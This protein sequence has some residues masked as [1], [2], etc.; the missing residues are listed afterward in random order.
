MVLVKLGVHTC[1]GSLR[2][3]FSSLHL[4]FSSF[5]KLPQVIR[6]LVF[7]VFF[8]VSKAKEPL[9]QTWA[10]VLSDTISE[11]SYLDKVLLSNQRKTYLK[12]RKD[13]FLV[14]CF[15]PITKHKAG[16]IA[17]TQSMSWIVLVE[18]LRSQRSTWR[19]GE[20]TR[21]WS[22]GRDSHLWREMA[23]SKEPP[24]FSFYSH[25]LPSGNSLFTFRK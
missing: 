9:S 17:S 24:Q 4:S 19:H 21:V 22:S 15:Y 25:I 7:S 1:L 23:H 13:I 5:Q 12:M 14:F 18:A 10:F 11:V 8:S 3:C 20:M 2:P 6:G 16:H